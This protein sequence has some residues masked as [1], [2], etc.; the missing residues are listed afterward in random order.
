MEFSPGDRLVQTVDIRTDCGYVLLVHKDPAVVAADFERIVALQKTMFSVQGDDD[1]DEHIDNKQLSSAVKDEPRRQQQVVADKP[2]I[3]SKSISVEATASTEST[4]KIPTR[5]REGGKGGAEEEAQVRKPLSVSNTAN[6]ESKPAPAPAAPAVTKGRVSPGS[7][8]NRP[9]L[10]S[11]SSAAPAATA[12]A[13]AEEE[14]TAAKVVSLQ[15]Q[16][17]RV[18]A[19]TSA[20]ASPLATAAPG[21]RRAA[22][23]MSNGQSA[24]SAVQLPP[25][26]V[27]QVKQHSSFS[28]S[29]GGTEVHSVHTSTSSPPP[30]VREVIKTSTEVTG[31]VA[32]KEEKV[33]E[34]RNEQANDEE[35]G[36]IKTAEGKPSVETAA[37]PTMSSVEAIETIQRPSRRRARQNAKTVDNGTDDLIYRA[38]PPAPA[39]SSHGASTAPPAMGTAAAGAAARSSRGV[40]QTPPRVAFDVADVE[41]QH[42]LYSSQPI[43]ETQ[44][45][46][47]QTD[48][49]VKFQTPQAATKFSVLTDEKQSTK[50]FAALSGSTLVRLIRKLLFGSTV[51]YASSLVVTMVVVVAVLPAFTDSIL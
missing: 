18:T 45:Q 21:V 17:G 22:R 3:G 47:Q 26:G 15:Q 32:G 2:K 4:A 50:L 51:I 16:G 11:K 35:H 9:R 6:S 24:T 36:G 37:K 29:D 8:S 40:R 13:H 42:A 33:T 39:A 5:D 38:S 44:F 1:D 23:P 10:P 7:P 12:A 48:D 34:T 28:Q 31:K 43:S 30:G 27:S 41:Q 14:E 49:A 25:A 46:Q 19:S 20:V